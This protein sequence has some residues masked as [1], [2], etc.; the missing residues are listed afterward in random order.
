MNVF[1][2]PTK[3]VCLDLPTESSEKFLTGRLGAR[4]RYSQRFKTCEPL[5]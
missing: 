2:D 5:P 1:R 3:N 4:T